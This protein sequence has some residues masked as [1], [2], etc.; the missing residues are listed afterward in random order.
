M[1]EYLSHLLAGRH[2]GD[3]HVVPGDHHEITHDD[4]AHSEIRLH[5]S[6]AMHCEGERPG[7]GPSNEDHSN[8][9]LHL[10]LAA[11]AY[12]NSVDT[13]AQSN[14]SFGGLSVPDLPDS[15]HGNAVHD[16]AEGTDV[17]EE[18]EP[19][20]PVS[21]HESESHESALDFFNGYID[22]M[23]DQF[24]GGHQPP[25]QQDMGSESDKDIDEDEVNHGEESSGSENLNQDLHQLGHDA[26]D[27]HGQTSGHIGNLSSDA[28]QHDDDDL[29]GADIDES[30][31]YGTSVRDTYTYD[32]IL[33]ED[34]Y[35]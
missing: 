2:A 11:P 18:Q 19:N 5:G 29:Q 21:G 17:P 8:H 25:V 27:H 23:L 13:R 22:A 16:E 34:L 24:F 3:E 30:A 28:V 4:H 9:D 31:S 10:A 35:G 33:D 1:L 15:M 7:Y 32:S 12:L 20:E 26:V 6:D 14:E